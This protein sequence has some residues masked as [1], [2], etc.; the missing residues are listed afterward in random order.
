MIINWII[1]IDISE[2]TKIGDNFVIWHGI[3]LVIHP[4][5]V[6]G[7][8]CILRHCTTIGSKNSINDVPILG[9]NV[10]VGSN[11]VDRKSVV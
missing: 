7:D 6:I 2:F 5:V 11:S 4:K 8:N 3:G 10:E 9:N 1:G